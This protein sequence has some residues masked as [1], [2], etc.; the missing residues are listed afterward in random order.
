MTPP[1]LQPP[2]AGLPF[3]SRLAIRGLG[4]FML[5]R[6]FTWDT[7][8]ASVEAT[9]LRMLGT[10]SA[11]DGAAFHRPVLVPP[12]R[13]LEDSSRHW[14]PAMV[15]EHLTL[16]APGFLHFILSL[17]RGETTDRVVD[18]ALVKP[19]GTAGRDVEVKFRE[20]HSGVLERIARE[21]GPHR[22]TPRH[23]HP[24]FGP[25]GAR[26]W[27]ALFA[28]HLLLHEKQL[29]AILNSTPVGRPGST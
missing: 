26:D 24:W 15:L 28:V 7:A 22:R 11:L 2:G 4:R 21:S 9:A 20:L 1:K 6:K 29:H 12:M 23:R 19:S 10:V 13:G 3:F 5:R 18:T 25:L 14:S 17:S 16:T 27:S 8:P